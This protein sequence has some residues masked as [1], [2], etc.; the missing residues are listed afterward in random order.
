MD[1]A[2]AVA[3]QRAYWEAKQWW[4]DVQAAQQRT[5]PT[6]AQMA[7]C[8]AIADVLGRA[9]GADWEGGDAEPS[10]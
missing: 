2:E 9:L 5:E 6:P 8:A 4:L 7:E 3:R 1:D 10:A